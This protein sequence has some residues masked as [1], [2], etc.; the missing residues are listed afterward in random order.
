MRGGVRAKEAKGIG[1]ES[2]GGGG[3]EGRY[4]CHCAMSMGVMRYSED[5]CCMKCT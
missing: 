4:K 2:E 5:I 3:R 1:P